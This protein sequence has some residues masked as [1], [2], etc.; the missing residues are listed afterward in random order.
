MRNFDIEIWL[1]NIW[2]KIDDV[3]KKAF[4]VFFISMNV[5]YLYNSV[6]CL[7]GNHDVHAMFNKLPSFSGIF[8]GRYTSAFLEPYISNKTMIPMFINIILFFL[9]SISVVLLFNWFKV[10]KTMFNF[11]LPGLFVLLTP[12]LYSILWYRI[13]AFGFLMTLFFMI[14]SFFLCEKICAEEKK[15]QKILY[16]FF[17]TFFMTVFVFGAYQSLLCTVFGLLFIMIFSDILENNFTSTVQVFKR[18]IPHFFVSILSLLINFIIFNLLRN[19]GVIDLEHYANN[20]I[21]F[22][23]FFQN[24]CSFFV[25]TIQ[26]FCYETYPY[27]GIHYKIIFVLIVLFSF[28]SVCTYIKNREKNKKKIVLKIFFSICSYLFIFYVFNSIYFLSTSLFETPRMLRFEYWTTIYFVFGCIVLGLKYANTLF[29]NIL[30]ILVSLSIFYSVQICFKVQQD[31]VIA[32][33]IEQYR[34]H[35]VKNLILSN[36]NYST[37]NKYLYIQIG[38]PEFFDYAQNYRFNSFTN[39]FVVELGR[40]FA[41]G[42]PYVYSLVHLPPE[43][44]NINRYYI[45]ELTYPSE[46]KEFLDNDVKNWLLTDAKVYPSPDSVFIN[47]GRI[48][49]VMDE[50]LLLA[51]KAEIK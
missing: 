34:I 4:W 29:K 32:Q 42:S 46:I 23:N 3:D 38:E 20:L 13:T 51:I 9:L 11:I 25:R 33:N 40:T 41:N 45:K 8:M 5:V 30:I 37:E 22:S 1:S 12:C 2:K 6:F 19:K 48:F 21:G 27:I 17:A 18:Y 50:T 31:Q 14:V 35:I 43:I 24:L 16:F 15:Y 39:D 49:I 47:K 44:K 26:D 7:F 36:K 28:L 10:K